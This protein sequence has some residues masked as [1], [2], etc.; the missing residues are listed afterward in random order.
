MLV[1][2]TI[3][4]NHKGAI[5]QRMALNLAVTDV[6]PQVTAKNFIWEPEY[7]ESVVE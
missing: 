1:N 3:W 2:V 4:E 6:E 5:L 7:V